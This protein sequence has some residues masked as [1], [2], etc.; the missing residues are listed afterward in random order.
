MIMKNLIFVS[1][2]FLVIS[3]KEN[4]SSIDPTGTYELKG[5]NIDGGTKGYSGEIRVKLIENKKIAVN[6]YI[7]KGHPSYNEGTFRDTLNYDHN[8]A[9][10]QDK[11]PKTACTLTLDFSKEGVQ[12]KENAN[13]EYGSCWGNG[14]VAHG[15]FKKTSAKIPGN[16]ELMEE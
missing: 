4:P 2:I 14:V 10:Y 12:I 9:V 6:F 5:E 8:R 15:F 1:L 11:D 3:C 16:P 13:Y 7:T